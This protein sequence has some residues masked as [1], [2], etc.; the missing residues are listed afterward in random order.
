MIRRVDLEGKAH[1]PIE[2]P[3]VVDVVIDRAPDGTERPRQDKKNTRPAK[4]IAQTQGPGLE[5]QREQ[6]RANLDMV[7]RESDLNTVKI[8]G[9]GLEAQRDAARE[10]LAA[11]NYGEKTK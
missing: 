2:T 3:H 4:Q 6:A 5:A 1:G 7:N 10:R 11:D 8:Q 9:P